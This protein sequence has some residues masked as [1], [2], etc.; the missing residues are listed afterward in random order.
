MS[1][2]IVDD[3]PESRGL[4]AITLKK[5]GYNVF[6]AN[7]GLEALEIYKNNTISIVITDWMMPNMDGLTLCDEIRKFIKNNYTYIIIATAK[8]QS[9]DIKEAL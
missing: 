7:D 8:G 5:W 6:T 9:S 1:I 2:L 3:S 4:L